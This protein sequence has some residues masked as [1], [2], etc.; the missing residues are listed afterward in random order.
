MS[1]TKEQHLQHGQHPSTM[2]DDQK[3]EL[4]ASDPSAFD[5]D[6]P[7]PSDEVAAPAAE[8]KTDGAEGEAAAG[9]GGEGGD[10]QPAAGFIPKGRLN[11]ALAQRDRERERAER[12]EAEIAE[13]RAGPKVDYD[14][15]IRKLDATWDGEGD[16]EFDG[17][18]ADY[19]KQR[20]TL[21][22]KR[23]EQ[24][25]REAVAK[26]AMERQQQQHA[27]QWTHDLQAFLDADPTHAI[28]GQK[29]AMA[30][31]LTAEVQE[32]YNDTPGLSNADL[33]AKA[34]ANLTSALGLQA[35]AA[36]PQGPHAARNAADARA[37]A[38]ASA[39]PPAINGGVG[40]RGTPSADQ[41]VGDDTT[42]DQWR[43]LSKEEKAKAL[44]GDAAL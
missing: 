6:A 7:A 28:Y 32:V 23:V 37:T 39:A 43:R 1:D 21:V 12:A 17:T 40:A 42:P 33:L 20:D 2:T 44:G 13:L 24:T 14:E 11:E 31:A 25:T 35:P 27:E 34:H 26:E 3:A 15:E 22:A 5:D 10:T 29:K 8:A 38:A 36:A 18:H 4:R 16:D 19:L 30:D 41:T 9:D